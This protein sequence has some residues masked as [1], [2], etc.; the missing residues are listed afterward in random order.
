VADD[1][2]PMS[3]LCRRAN[4]DEAPG[5]ALRAVVSLRN[6]LDELERRHVG[7]LVSSGASWSEVAAALGISRQAAHRRFRDLPLERAPARAKTQVDRILVTGTARTMVQLAREEASTQGAP[8]VGTEHLLVALIRNA[9]ESLARTLRSAGID[10]D[11][12]RTSLQPT[13]VDDGQPAQHDA[14]FTR[15]AREV[16]E[17]ALREAV[18]RG[19]GY[20]GAEHLLLALL[21][22]PSGGAAQTFDALG[23]DP[24][25]VFAG[26][27][28]Q[29]A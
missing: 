22:N 13:V 26:L 11:R 2:T 29:P 19:E 27:S 18:D 25:V 21:R 23:V 6:R 10:E 12:L 1:L 3:E 15:N 24:Q 20:I 14:R 7:A 8:L 16:L 17:G 28:A 5:D 9:P 4:G